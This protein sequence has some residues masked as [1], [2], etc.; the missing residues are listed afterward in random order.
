MHRGQYSGDSGAV[1]VEFAFVLPLLVIIF[2]G[3]VQFGLVLYRTQMLEAAAREGARVAS[4]GG[5]TDDV[6]ARV[7][8]SAANLG[9]TIPPVTIETR[10]DSAGSWASGGCQQRGDDV[11]V[12]V[13]VPGDELGFD[14]PFLGSFE[15][16]YHA[17]A[18]FR[19]ETAT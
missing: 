2:I 19:C 14:I 17:A 9:V 18:T 7:E 15:P 10:T 13:S 6:Q 5:E 12:A 1:A 11:R 8:S 4:V 16:D 3:T